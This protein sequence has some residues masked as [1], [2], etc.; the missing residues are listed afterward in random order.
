MIGIEGI[1][2]TDGQVIKRALVTAHD[3]HLERAVELER[4]ADFCLEPA[5]I[6]K[7]QGVAQAGGKTN[8]RKRASELRLEAAGQRAIA[9][10]IARVMNILSPPWSGGMCPN[11][12]S[13]KHAACCQRCGALIPPRRKGL[14]FCTGRCERLQADD[15]HDSAVLEEIAC[16]R[17]RKERGNG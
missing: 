8:M 9:A 4:A 5:R 2:A 7:S 15:D 3:R 10:D 14:A 13:Q 12:G 11:C 16:E 17:E 6:A 1:S